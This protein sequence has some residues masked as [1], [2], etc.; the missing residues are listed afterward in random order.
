MS[1][2]LQFRVVHDSAANNEEITRIFIETCLTMKKSILFFINKVAK[3][4]IRNAQ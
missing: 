3:I 2:K 4:A 1:T